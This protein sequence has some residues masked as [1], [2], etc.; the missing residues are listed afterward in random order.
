MSRYMENLIFRVIDESEANSW[1]DAVL[2]WEI[3][4][5][6]EDDELSLSCICG[7]ENLR[8][9]YTIRNEL[10]G[11]VL[12]P[13]GSSCIKKFERSDLNEEIIV[14]EGMFKLYRAIRTRTFIE[15]SSEFFSRRLLNA[16]YE[17]G[18]FRANQYNH[19]NGENDYLFMVDMF[20]KR[21]KDSISAAQQSKINAII[22]WSIIPYLESELKF[23]NN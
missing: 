10:N 17:R 7:K 23:R 16:L 18:A 19:Y 14:R 5:C 22:R 2:E 6:E 1:N 15:L 13:I 8:Y 3:I 12:F 20:N 4:D 21:N 9:L 11:K